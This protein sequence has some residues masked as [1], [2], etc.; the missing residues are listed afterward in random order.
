M[1][2]DFSGRYKLIFSP[3]LSLAYIKR[4]KAAASASP[5]ASLPSYTVNDVILAALAGALRLYVKGTRQMQDL[6][7]LR[8]RVL[9]P[10][11]FPRSSEEMHN[12]W[13]M[14]SVPLPAHEGHQMQ[15]LDEVAK[16]MIQMKNSPAGLLQI[17]VQRA[18]RYPGYPDPIPVFISVS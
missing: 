10:F 12:L 5:L 4:L 8:Q 15:R 6:G 14:L 17:L 9:L 11:A 3:R 1:R 13:C 2:F 18:V 7:K 16:R